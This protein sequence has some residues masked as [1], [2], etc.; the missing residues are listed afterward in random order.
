[1]KRGL[2]LSVLFCFASL[3]MSGSVR[4]QDTNTRLPTLDQL[5]E[6]WNALAPG[7]DTICARGT[8]YQ[9][10][11]R[12]GDPSKLMLYFEGGGGCWDDLTCSTVNP[13]F[14]ASVTDDEPFAYSGIFSN[15]GSA[16]PVGDYSTVFISYCSG[17]FFAG[18]TEQTYRGLVSNYTIQ[19]R[20]YVNTRAVLDWA[21]AN[22]PA[23][24]HLLIT[25]SSAGSIGAIVHANSILQRY[26]AANPEIQAALFGD[27]GVG[28]NPGNIS[29]FDRWNALQF[30]PQEGAFVNVQPENLIIDLTHAL[31]QTYPDLPIGEFTNAQDAVQSVFYRMLGGD[32]SQWETVMRSDLAGL[33]SEP[34]FRS[35]IADGDGHT[36]LALPTF[37]TLRQDNMSFREWFSAW[38]QGD[39]VENVGNE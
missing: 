17:D 11:V 19:H 14:D 37:Y 9:F 23:P 8:P 36:I 33:Q 7:G 22:Y 13:I 18:D 25:G 29:V 27:A 15:R 28:V 21:Y 20:G 6:G 24:E 31:A 3:L 10:F 39:P 2:F 38:L 30:L 5:H 34:N 12:P 32:E 1:M 35:Y 16:N 26:L 4:A